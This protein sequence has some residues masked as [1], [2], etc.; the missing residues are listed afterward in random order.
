MS[1]SH[2][3]SRG[4]PP[5]HPEVVEAEGRT[6]RTADGRTLLDG[7]SGALAAVVGYGVPEIGEAVAKQA[8][9]L[10][11]AHSLHFTTEVAEAYAA[12][13]ADV[14]PG[15][16]AAALSRILFVTGGS[17]ANELAL[18]MAHRIQTL[19]G[20][21]GRCLFLGRHLS[22]HGSTLATLALG[23]RHSLRSRVEVLLPTMAHLPPPYPYRPEWHA[24][25][26]ES[27]SGVPGLGD[28]LAGALSE[29]ALRRAQSG[30]AEAG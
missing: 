26:P 2:L 3:L 15:A 23:A 16:G 19:R 30:P 14:L 8:R 7:A 25:F 10:A 24:R 27:V 18:L 11:F 5:G 20:E 21:P 1:G 12:E 17:E 13:L 29:E 28:L 6:I 22:Y 9:E 4:W